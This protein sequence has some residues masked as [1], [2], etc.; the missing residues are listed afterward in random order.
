MLAYKFRLYP[1]QDEERK[2]L[3]TLELCRRAYN[4]MLEQYN[5]KQLSLY[6]MGKFL[7]NLKTEWTELRE[8]VSCSFRSIP[9]VQARS[10]LVA[11]SSF[12]IQLTTDG[13]NARTAGCRCHATITLRSMSSIED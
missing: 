10:A 7:T 3:W 11:V 9:E 13:A 5:E 6:E 4:R 8:L 1:N 2:L 12:Q